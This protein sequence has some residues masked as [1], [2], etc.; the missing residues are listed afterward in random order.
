M[1]IKTNKQKKKPLY[2]SEGLTSAFG[3]TAPMVPFGQ[4]FTFCL[5]Q[6]PQ[7]YQIFAPFS[8]ARS[9]QLPAACDFMC[10]I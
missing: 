7:Q 10:P 3:E 6:S 9:Q 5:Q 1:Q 8:P 4:P 2:N